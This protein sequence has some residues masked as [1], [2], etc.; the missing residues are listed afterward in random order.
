MTTVEL[1]RFLIARILIKSTY[2]I[3]ENNVVAIVFYFIQDVLNMLV[4]I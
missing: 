3:K 2:M 1:R 4:F